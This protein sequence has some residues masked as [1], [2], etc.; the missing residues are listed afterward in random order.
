[1]F[2]LKIRLHFNVFYCLCM[3]VNKHYANFKGIGFLG[4]RMRNFQGSI[5]RTH[6]EIFKSVCLCTFKAGSISLWFPAPDGKNKFLDQKTWFFGIAVYRNI[7]LGNTYNNFC[8]SANMLNIRSREFDRAQY[9]VFD[10]WWNMLIKFI[11]QIL[12]TFQPW[13][14]RIFKRK[15][16]KRKTFLKLFWAEVATLLRKY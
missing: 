4:L 11:K 1:M 8:H 3:F 2:F 13:P 9:C 16:K 14:Q 5:L 15:A 7:W 12:N 10:M 6:R